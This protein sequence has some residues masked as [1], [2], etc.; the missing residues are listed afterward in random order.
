MHNTVLTYHHILIHLED[1]TTRVEGNKIIC[2]HY[3]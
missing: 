3:Y 1:K 2:H